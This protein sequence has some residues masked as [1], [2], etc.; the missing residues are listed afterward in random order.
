MYGNV[1]PKKMIIPIVYMMSKMQTRK[2]ETIIMISY[3]I[4]KIIFLG[5]RLP[6]IFGIITSPPATP[7][8]QNI[9]PANGLNPRPRR[10]IVLLPRLRDQGGWTALLPTLNMP[11]A[12]QTAPLTRLVLLFTH[13]PYANNTLQLQVS[14]YI[15]PS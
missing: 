13:P 9:S 7:F 12:L 5:I 15:S 11:L 1:M 3:I 2:V 4:G 8:H 14:E 10:T 6:Y